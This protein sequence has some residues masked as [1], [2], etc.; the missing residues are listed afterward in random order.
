MSDHQ[1]GGP[2][3]R[4]ALVTGASRGIGRALAT[5]LARAGW[6]LALLGRDRVALDAT[7]EQCGDV[8]VLTLEGD[9]RL[10]ADVTAAVEA[11]ETALGPLSAL[12]NNAGAQHVGP[13]LELS[14]EH[15]DDIVD[16]NLKGAFLCSQAAGRSMLRR[17]GGGAIVNIASAAALV[18]TTGRAAYAASKAGLVMLTRTL[19][20]EWAPHRIRVN[21][22]APTFVDTDLGRQTLADP[23]SR[24]AVVAAI[25][26]GRVA[27]Y[28]DI[29]PAVEYLL[30]DGRAG[31]VTGQV[32]AVDGGLSA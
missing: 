15:L 1:S 20:R 29:V 6:D 23:A 17:G 2:G 18:G 25:P 11:A 27:G 5:G 24:A 31:F 19:A 13:A 14:P 16:T 4:V 28:D 32:L 10:A 22:V 12:V 9:V 3:G 30:D 21:A 8:R 26:L 7:A